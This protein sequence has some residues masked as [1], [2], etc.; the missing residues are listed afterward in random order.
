MI[1]IDNKAF[2]FVRGK[3]LCFVV[4]VKK[5]PIECDC[6]NCSADFKALKVKVLFETEVLDKELYNVYEYEGIKVFI[7]KSL[8]A[9]GDINIYQKKKIPF[10]EPTFG[11]KGII[12]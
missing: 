9:D 6:C 3:N 11:V 1:K 10:M 12:A 7:S 5:T 2:D 4:S 8:K